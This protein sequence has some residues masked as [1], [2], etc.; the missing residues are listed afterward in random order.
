MLGKRPKWW[1]WSTRK[2]ILIVVAIAMSSGVALSLTMVGTASAATVGS[3]R[4]S[5]I[6]LV[7]T[8]QP[9][10]ATGCVGNL[11]TNNVRTCIAIYGTGT[12]ITELDASAYIRN[13]A[14]IGHIQVH[15]PSLNFNW[16]S[17]GTIVMDTGYQYTITPVFYVTVSPG[18][19]CATTWSPNGSGGYYTWGSACVTVIA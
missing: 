17:S 9:D 7:G 16:P 2:L 14:I 3:S 5:G 15:G 12:S 13:Y 18:K 6:H 10:T 1:P 4:G 19:Y 8:V 11:P